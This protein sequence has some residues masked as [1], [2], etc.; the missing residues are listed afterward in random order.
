MILNIEETSS[1]LQFELGIFIANNIL[2]LIMDK[3]KLKNVQVLIA[4]LGF[5]KRFEIERY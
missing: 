3:R 2:M 1:S 4:L 5:K